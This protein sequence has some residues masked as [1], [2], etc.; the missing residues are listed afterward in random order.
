MERIS[1]EYH[2]PND[3]FRKHVKELYAK[4]KQISALNSLL[5][6]DV[7]SMILSEVK[8]SNFKQKFENHSNYCYYS[9]LTLH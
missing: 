6:E 1:Y 9:V 8:K 2:N 3:M 7:F 4:A 5:V